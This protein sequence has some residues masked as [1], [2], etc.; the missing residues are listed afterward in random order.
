MGVD[1]V[2]LSD[3][4]VDNYH[5]DIDKYG[6]SKVW[7]KYLFII[8]NDSQ[9]FINRYFPLEFIGFMYEN[10]YLYSQTGD[11]KLPQ[12]QFTPSD[13]SRIVAELIAD[14]DIKT[15]SDVCCGN[16]NLI[17]SILSEVK[18][19]DIQL[20]NNLNDKIYLYDIDPLALKVAAARIKSL[21]SLNIPEKNLLLGD[22]LSED[23]KLPPYTYAVCNPPLDN[24]GYNKDYFL[25]FFDKILKSASKFVFIGPQTI[26]DEQKY[27][28]FRKKLM[29]NSFGDIFCFDN[30]PDALY[31]IE[32]G[33][34]GMKT[35]IINGECDFSH[36]GYRLTHL[37]RFNKNERAKV[38]TIDYLLSC[39]G[40][41]RQDLVK[42]LKLH[43][44]TEDFVVSCYQG[45]DTLA[46]L[47]SENKNEFSLNVI[48]SGRYYLAACKHEIKRHGAF[49]IYAKDSDSF[50]ILYLLLNS[51]YCY[52]F[53]RSIGNGSI[54]SKKE[55]LSYP[56]PKVVLTEELRTIVK[57][58]INQ[59]N[60]LI[61]SKFVQG[62]LQEHLKF[63]E[64]YCEFIDN[65]LFEKNFK[66]LHK[67]YEISDKSD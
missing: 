62:E 48:N 60:K 66:F 44:K 45:E 11:N 31:P 7:E 10:G 17:I 14:S 27:S 35:C 54:L 64:I 43:R 20:L 47:C 51:S 36:R 32:K 46:S 15:I 56:Y 38:L 23:I 41:I 40:T 53:F 4:I 13:V 19:I 9:K 3:K 50:V 52:L 39:L 63:P 29:D 28:D 33:N 21:F 1:E 34:F 12:S 61:K 49:K 2:K 24:K 65:L 25:F 30:V 58:M 57:F 26:V 6:F 8:K 37:I 59:E 5:L 55:L 42:P 22:F 18:K 67:N 16:G